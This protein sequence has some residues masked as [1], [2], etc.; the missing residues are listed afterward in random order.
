MVNERSFSLVI[1]NKHLKDLNPLF[2]GIDQCLPGQHFPPT[3][4]EY[5][6]IQYV[7]SGKGRLRL[8]D[9][10]YTV[11]PQQIFIIPKDTENFYQADIE[12]P[13]SIIWIGFTGHLAEHFS[14]LP[15]VLEFP[16]N[17]FFEMLEVRRL[18]TMREEFLSEKLFA[19]FRFLFSKHIPNNYSA[20]VKN[21]IKT[22][23]MDPSISVEQIAQDLG[24]NRS[25]L[26]RL[27]KQEYKCSVQE[28][29]I[30]TR[31]AQAITF[32]NMGHDVQLVSSRVGYT[33]ASNF[34][35]IFKKYTG[36]SPQKYQNQKNI[37]KISD[38]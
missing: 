8:K 18:D 19:L 11:S 5:C 2:F 20:A 26:S 38:D 25:Y 3:I 13:W 36:V 35:K 9:T 27:F 1:E 6:L 7:I 12:E 28:Y 33:D 16:S 32:L 31:I 30:R 4:R 29:L 15:P 17:I 37:E 21:F 14:Q 24:L 22:N 10:W 23:Y 34:S